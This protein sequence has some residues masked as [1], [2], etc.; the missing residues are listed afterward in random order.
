M[1]PLG[2]NRTSASSEFVGGL[3]LALWRGAGEALMGAPA[4]QEDVGCL[5]ASSLTW[6]PVVTAIEL[7]APYGYLKG[8]ASRRLH[9]AVGGT[10]AGFF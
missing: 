7:E 3:V 4:D 9:H 10:A 5:V 6:L 8:F 1:H 2:A